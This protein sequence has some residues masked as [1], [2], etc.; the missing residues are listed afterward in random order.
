MNFKRT[1]GQSELREFL[2]YEGR[3]SIGA[4]AMNKRICHWPYCSRCGLVA[5][6]ND[7][8]RKALRSPCVVYE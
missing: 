3:K 4:H 6:K 5:L 8:T 7:I 2:E 1:L